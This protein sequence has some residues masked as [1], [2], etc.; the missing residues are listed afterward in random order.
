MADTG[1]DGGVQKSECVRN[2]VAKI[3]ARVGDGFSD[4]T[5][6]GEMHDGVDARQDAVKLGLVCDVALDQF[7]A[8]G[9]AAEAGGEIVVNDDLITRSAQCASGVTADIARASYYQNR[10]SRPHLI[11]IEPAR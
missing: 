3:F 11:S 7:E 1:I 4:I 10:Q 5:V 2:I 9:Q 6:G 8:F